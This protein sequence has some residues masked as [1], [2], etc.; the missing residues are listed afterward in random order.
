MKN[1]VTF[2]KSLE[3]GN[4]SKSLES[5]D[6][7]KNLVTSRGGPF[8][9]EFDPKFNL[10]QSGFRC[11]AKLNLSYILSFYELLIGSYLV[12]LSWFPFVLT[13]DHP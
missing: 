1:L 5:S 11:A 9:L 3:S 2:T 7:V 4:V 8:D 10:D 13:L 6:F 12:P